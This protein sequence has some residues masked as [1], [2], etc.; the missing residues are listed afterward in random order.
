[1]RL[2]IIT[3]NMDGHV[4]AQLEPTHLRPQH[5]RNTQRIPFRRHELHHERFR[6]WVNVDDGADAAWLQGLPTVTDNVGC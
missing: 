3:D 6:A 5:S 4:Q 1:M 2:F